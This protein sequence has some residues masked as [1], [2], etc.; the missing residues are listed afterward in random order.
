MNRFEQCMGSCGDETLV[1]NRW[2]L[3]LPLFPEPGERKR[4]SNTHTCGNNMTAWLFHLVS[5]R[6]KTIGKD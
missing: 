6:K 4:V 5:I 2:L 3:F 1:L